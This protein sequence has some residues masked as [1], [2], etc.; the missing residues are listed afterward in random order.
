MEFTRNDRLKMLPGDE[1]YYIQDSRG[2]V[3]NSVLWWGLESRGYVCDMRRAQK[4]TK[5]QML[6]ICL[7]GRE[8]D[9]PWIAS[10][11]EEKISKL[12]P[13]AR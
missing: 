10:H 5:Q 6:E 13:S 12:K 3:G 11:V 1:M 4:Y 9:I 2:Y 7:D 8:T